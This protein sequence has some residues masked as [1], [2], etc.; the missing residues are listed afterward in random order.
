[1]EVTHKHVLLVDDNV[2]LAK[3]I[4]EYLELHGIHSDHA[5]NGVMAFWRCWWLF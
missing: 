1:M 4:M 2:E 5:A 3:T